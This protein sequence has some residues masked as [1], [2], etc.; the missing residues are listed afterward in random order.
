MKIKLK[1][2][3]LFVVDNLILGGVSKVLVDLLKKLDYSKYNIDLLVLHFYNDMKI[4]IPPEVNIIKGSKTFSLV[5]E[6]ISKLIKEKNIIKIIKKLLFSFKIKSGL[7]KYDILK[8]RKID[9]Q[10]TY[11]IEIAFGDGFPYFYVGLGNANKKI[12]WM[13]SDVMVKDYSAR[14]Y[15]QMKNILKKMD[16]GVAV[17]NKICES[18]KTKYKLNNIEIINNIIDDEEIL[19]KSNLE[20]DIPWDNKFLNFLSVGRLDYS[21]NYDM[22]LRVSK[23][24]ID[25]NYNFKIF[26]IGDGHEKEN[27]DK[28]IR[29]MN[30]EKHFILLGK[31]DNPYPYIKNCDMFLLSSRYEGLPTVIIEALILHIPCLSTDVAGI[32]ELLNTNF[33]IISDNN[34][35]DFYLK[36]KEV[37]SNQN[38]IN[39]MKKNLLNYK[40]N[41]DILIS[42]I[43][44]IFDN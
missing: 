22:L 12:A 42:K 44:K 16:L 15:K 4:G 27:L 6:N 5:D 25:E 9:L 10:K 32:H 37:L 2:N 13:H 43:E 35:K 28:L 1:K 20:I 31:K 17:S 33:G 21:K 30:M 38:L 24:L 40:Y 3:I 14:Y 29:D 36:F 23:K 19:K 7:I 26:I 18:Y 34:E 39:D 41:N 8:S 11:D